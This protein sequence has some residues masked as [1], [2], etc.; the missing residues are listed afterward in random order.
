[1]EI[2]DLFM[3]RLKE[4]RKRKDITQEKLSELSGINP[5]LISKYEQ[6]IALPGIDNLQK[7]VVAL[8]I[9]ADYFLLPQAYP[10]MVPK[11]KD[12]ELYDRYFALETLDKQERDHALFLLNL[13]VTQK[14]FKE[15]A[16]SLETIQ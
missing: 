10:T 7:L 15:F 12:P 6:G 16:S 2:K 3:K 5:T 11:V 1:M 14:K 4:A 8:E 13:I 9:S